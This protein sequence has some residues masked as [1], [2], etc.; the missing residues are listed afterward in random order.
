MSLLDTLRGMAAAQV[1]EYPQYIGHFDAY[2]LV[3]I[4]RPIRT[5]LGL[6]F[7]AGEVAIAA[8]GA[9]P[10]LGGGPRFR[11]VWSLRNRIDTS[12]PASAVEAA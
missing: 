2:T 6:A 9:A 12:V 10:I 5:K 3:R 11:T 1:A 4:K 7:D 8:P